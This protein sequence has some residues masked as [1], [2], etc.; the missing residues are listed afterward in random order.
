MARRWILIVQR[1]AEALA[2]LEKAF[3]DTAFRLTVAAD[4]RLGSL[5]ARELKP[6]AIVSD[7]PFPAD[8]VLDGIP[9][10]LASMP[11][12]EA[13]LKA[14]ILALVE[15]ENAPVP[16]PVAAPAPPSTPPPAP[17]IGPTAKHR[18][19]IAGG[20]PAVAAVVE[21]AVMGME[22]ETAAARDA[23]E[24]FLQARAREPLLVVCDLDAPE[25]GGGRELLRGL[26]EGGGMSAVPFIFVGEGAAP[27]EEPAARFLKKP[28]D[29]E[30]LRSLILHLL[31][32]AAEESV[33]G[34][35]AAAEPK[36]GPVL[37]LMVD[38]VVSAVLDR[39]LVELGFPAAAGDASRALDQARDLKPALIISDLQAAGAVDLLTELRLDALL[40]AIPFLF[41]G[42]LTAEQALA[43]LP[44]GDSTV[45]YMKKPLDLDKLKAVVSELTDQAGQ[46]AS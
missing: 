23:A 43:M 34:P 8:A 13:K 22:L 4:E 35:E 27:A 42:G 15:R 46:G 18:L 1:D 20:D 31:T 32:G 10:L 17:P 3:I 36:R 26:R 9:F 45:R 12:D 7:R 14:W 33:A 40:R 37:V 38:A 16:A 44:W 30:R 19:L 29:S 11:F 5:Q 25:L 28:L 41:I 2:I 21:L 24:F 39:A 6:A